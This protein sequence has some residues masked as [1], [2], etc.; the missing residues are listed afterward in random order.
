LIYFLDASA[1]V[2]RYVHERGSDYIRG[3]VR[4]KRRLAASQLSLVEVTCAIWRRSRAGDLG[5]GDAK[6]LIKQLATDLS[7]LEVLE[8]RTAVLL[9]AT[10]VAERHPLRAYDAV[11]LASALRLATSSGIATTFVCSDE[12]LCAAAVAEGLR[13]H[14]IG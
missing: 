2:K 1:L 13:T 9:L 11:Q 12:N 7:E 5:G 10:A 3:L 6:R 8:A 14:P 4:R